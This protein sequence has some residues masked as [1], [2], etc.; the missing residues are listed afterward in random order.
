MCHSTDKKDVSGYPRQLYKQVAREYTRQVRGHPL[1]RTTNT[2]PQAAF[3]QRA[4]TRIISRLAMAL[5]ATFY[6][7][8]AI[9]LLPLA[10]NLSMESD[11]PKKAT[12]P[13]SQIDLRVNPPVP[14]AIF[15]D[16]HSDPTQRGRSVMDVYVGVKAT[17]RVKVSWMV[18]IHPTD[19]GS[20]F[21]QSAT[22]RQAYIGGKGIRQGSPDLARMNES[23]K[24]AQSPGC[25]IYGESESVDGFDTLAN[26]GRESKE[27]YGLS[28]GLGI[29]GTDAVRVVWKRSTFLAVSGP[30]V[31]ARPPDLVVAPP[32]EQ[33]T[34]S[35]GEQPIYAEMAVDPPPGYSLEGSSGVDF[36]YGAWIWRRRSSYLA[37]IPVTGTGDGLSGMTA[38]G[39]SETALRR[40]STRLFWG[41]IILGIVGNL[42]VAAIQ[43]TLDGSL[44]RMPH[45]RFQARHA[46]SHPHS[47]PS[48]P[49]PRPSAQSSTS[50]F[51]RDRNPRHRVSSP[52]SSQRE[53]PLKS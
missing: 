20:D 51:H 36:V 19:S 26:G 27:T 46:G 3:S 22:I 6:L 21:C 18:W 32:E 52:A 10:V 45:S 34:G 50:L 35:T 49:D 15:V 44:S 16:Y 40:E 33:G 24:H 41:G 29:P 48:Q 17:P 47:L 39:V 31:S 25:P 13:I 7:V 4:K 23:L 8:L 43:F 1:F 30:R 38:E 12:E 11:L 9:L 42:F 53:S 14:A 2:E 5:G 28:D 37:G